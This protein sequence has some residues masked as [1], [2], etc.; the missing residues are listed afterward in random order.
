MNKSLKLLYVED[1]DIQRDNFVGILNHYFDNITT[2]DN[3]ESALELYNKNKFDIVILDIM[4][5]NID[6][7]SVAKQIRDINSNT[8]IVIT[9]AYLDS[10]KLLKALKLQL[11]SYLVKPLKFEEID[12]T[13]K[14]L[15]SKL[16]KNSNIQLH[17]SYHWNN[18]LEKLYYKDEEIKISKNEKKLIS[19]L[20]THKG[21]YYTACDIASEILNNIDDDIKC[22][23][24]VQLISR[25]KKK[26]FSLHNDERFFIENVYGLGYKIGKTL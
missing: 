24:I 11:F 6:G 23:N 19:F 8:E 10:E 15:I 21:Q 3:G 9:T 20:S 13:M 5:P 22:N 12:S 4:L 25:F 16:S 1:D 26:M 7:L 17:S 2:T 14:K 18:N